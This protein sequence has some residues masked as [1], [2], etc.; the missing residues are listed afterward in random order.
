MPTW[1][2]ALAVGAGCLSLLVP[3]GLIVAVPIVS[4][5]SIVVSE[6]TS[7]V[8]PEAAPARERF[9]TFADPPMLVD[10]D[11]DGV[12][13]V[14]GLSQ[15][16][17]KSRWIGAHHGITGKELWRTD[18]LPESVEHHEARRALIGRYFVSV[19][20]V[21]VVRTFSV[22]SGALQWKKRISDRA[23]AICGGSGFV[24]IESVDDAVT[25]LALDDG[26]PV[27]GL[28]ASS[29]RADYDSLGKTTPEWQTVDWSE[30]DDHDLPDRRVAPG[31]VGYG[32][33]IPSQGKRVIW[34]GMRDPGSPVPMVSLLEDGVPRWTQVVPAGD[35]LEAQNSGIHRAAVSGE[36]VFIPYAMRAAEA[37]VRATCLRLTDGKRLWDAPLRTTLS[38]IDAVVASPQ[39]LFLLRG[40]SLH[41]QNA[42]DGAERFFIGYQ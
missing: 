36:R 9:R 30:F 19:D 17:G 42:S 10:V 15:H 22:D 7:V 39:T 33:L 4:N 5:W 37:N 31:M 1:A 14:V 16:L 21:A 13:D 26:I 27:V 8:P 35:P 34:L 2:L 24:R 25:T 20:S 38:N 3:L 18:D 40:N 23:R 28:D 11:R 32:A 6:T 29:C 41:A 12:L